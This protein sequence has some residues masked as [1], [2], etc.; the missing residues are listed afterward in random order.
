M[1]D[2]RHLHHL[3]QVALLWLY[4]PTRDW[5]FQARGGQL[6]RD[7]GEGPRG[8]LYVRRWR[9]L[10]RTGARWRQAARQH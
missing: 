5:E 9:R 10:E 1:H 4:P 6:W 2:Q 3:P 8:V 7:V